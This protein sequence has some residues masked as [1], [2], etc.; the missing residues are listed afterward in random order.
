MDCVGRGIPGLNEE[1]RESDLLKSRDIYNRLP[2]DSQQ[3][4]ISKSQLQDLAALFVRHRAHTTFGIH[5]AHSHFVIPEDT[6]LL[7]VNYDT[8]RCRW[9]KPSLIKTTNLSDVHGHV[10]VLT[11]HGFHPYEYQTGPVPDLSQVGSAFLQE[12]A[13]YL[14]INNLS[15]L[16]A[17]QV[18]GQK[19]AHMLELVLPE[20]TIMLDMAAL[21]TC[22]PTRQTGW[23][24][25]SV[26]GESRVCKSNESHG[27][28]ANGHDIYNEGAPHPK[29]ETFSDVTSAL[30][31]QG[32]LP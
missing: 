24:F 21:N 4:E 11:D 29:L 5:L 16:V 6:A 1:L 13:T 30:V 26:H 3:P 15:M 25:E 12:L 19:N 2:D 23:M 18:I 10:F 17:L 9:A 28:H 22:V 7:G 31:K 14:D 8:P 32:I 27:R 20:G